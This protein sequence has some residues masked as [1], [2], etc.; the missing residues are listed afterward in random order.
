[1]LNKVMLIGRLGR[2]PELRYTQTGSPIASL[3]IATDESYVDR[4]CRRVLTAKFKLGLFDD[5]YGDPVRPHIVFFGEAVPNLPAAVDLCSKADMF[6]V[7]GTSLQVYPA[8]SLVQYIRRDIPV[9]LVDP[10]T[11]DIRYI[12]NPFVHIKKRAAEG[13]PELVDE[14]MGLA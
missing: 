13:V 6:I 1:M 3:N 2:D 12:A 7:I 8:A 10:G 5:P 14:L 4:A 11:P 9:R